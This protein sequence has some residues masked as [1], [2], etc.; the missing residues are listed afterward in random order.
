MNLPHDPLLGPM[1][2]ER[3][4]HLAA[5]VRDR[6]GNRLQDFQLEADENG[7]VLSG[8]ARTYYVKQLAQHMIMAV[9]AVPIAAN[10]IMVLECRN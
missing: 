1:T 4:M 9:A 7:L 3:L 2:A 10:N 6:L 8:R 5:L